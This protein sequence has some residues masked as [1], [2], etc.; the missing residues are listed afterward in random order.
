MKIV[1]LKEFEDGYWFE[2]DLVIVGVGF[3]GFMVVC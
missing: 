1:D 2:V 3:V